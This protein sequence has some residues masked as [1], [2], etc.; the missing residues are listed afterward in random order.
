MISLFEIKQHDAW[1][2]IQGSHQ[3]DNFHAKWKYTII[4]VWFRLTQ[5]LDMGY[6]LVTMD[7]NQYNFPYCR[8]ANQLSF[9][10]ISGHR[11]YGPQTWQQR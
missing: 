3:I 2:N 1:K 11:I 5:S 4:A 9:V 7:Q 6:W 8:L 10:E